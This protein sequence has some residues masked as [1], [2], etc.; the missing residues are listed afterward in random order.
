MIAYRIVPVTPTDA[1]IEATAKRIRFNKDPRDDL[2]DDYRAMIESA[3]NGLPDA[4][5]DS[6]CRMMWGDKAHWHSDF[7]D[8]NEPM[9]TPSR[10]FHAAQIYR[11]SDRIRMGCFLLNLS[12]RDPYER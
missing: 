7:D 11:N 8:A 6:L 12:E 1:M 3:P 4:E 10:E 2:R 9:P 5:R